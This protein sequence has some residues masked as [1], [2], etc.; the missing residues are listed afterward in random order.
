M[1][2]IAAIIV[3]SNEPVIKGNRPNDSF[4][5]DTGD[6]VLLNNLLKSPDVISGN[7]SLNKN[8]NIRTTITTEINPFDSNSNLISLSFF[9]SI[10]IYLI[11]TYPDSSTIF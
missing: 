5:Y 3:T 6:Q 9:C 4:W 1:A 10:I 2:I 8:K 11:F 7:A